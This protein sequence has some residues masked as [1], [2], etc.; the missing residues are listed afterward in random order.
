MAQAFLI[1]ML[2]IVSYLVGYRRSERKNQE[3]KTLMA[4]MARLN[5]QINKQVI[6]KLDK[7][8][9]EVKYGR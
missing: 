9:K 5:D 1:A 8:L 6:Y 3:D 4:S 2:A 7:E